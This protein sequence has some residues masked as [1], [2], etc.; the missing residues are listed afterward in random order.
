MQN[1][2]RSV[3]RSEL[4]RKANYYVHGA[5]QNIGSAIFSRLKTGLNKVYTAFIV[6]RRAC[7][8]TR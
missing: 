4:E 2:L 5:N 1:N 3:E 7:P 8:G 6:K